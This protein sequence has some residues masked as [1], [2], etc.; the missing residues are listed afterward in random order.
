MI[1]SSI[2]CKKED[3]PLSR[4]FDR[5]PVAGS[6]KKR[7]WVDPGDDSEEEIGEEGVHSGQMM[8][9]GEVVN[10][11]VEVT[12][13]VQDQAPEEC[14][15]AWHAGKEHIQY[16]KS[17]SIMPRYQVLVDLVEALPEQVSWRFSRNT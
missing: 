8:K 16:V 9:S 5:R 14:S 1:V 3:A 4:Q 6:S 17:L 7:E 15:P 11:G 13:D 10:K 12:M 2:D